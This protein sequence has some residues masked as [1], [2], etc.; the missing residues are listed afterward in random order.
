MFCSRLLLEGPWEI[1][2]PAHFGVPCEL[3]NS[4]I[5][6]P[7]RVARFRAAGSSHAS[8]VCRLSVPL[9][10]G[11]KRY[12]STHGYLAVGHSAQ[13]HSSVH[14]LGPRVQPHTLVWHSVYLL[15]LPLRAWSSGTCLVLCWRLACDTGTCSCA[16]PT[17]CWMGCCWLSTE[18]GAGGPASA[19]QSPKLLATHV[20]H[21]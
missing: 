5:L 21:S 18:L 15:L 2:V 10:P 9:V 14:F 19:I 4:V 13:V 6:L 11:A 12:K 3:N 20:F 17:H 8:C 1:D 16:V 7:E